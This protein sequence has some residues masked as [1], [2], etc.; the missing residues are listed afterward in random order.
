V[1]RIRLRSPLLLAAVLAVHSVAPAAEPAPEAGKYFGITVVDEETGRGV[2]LVELRTVNDIR[3]VTDSAGR[4]AFHEPALMGQAVFFHVESHGYEFP[5]DG[6]GFRGRALKVTEGGRAEL[7][8]KRLNLAERLYRV[9]GAGIY[10]DSVLLGAEP[11]LRAPVLNGRVFGSD[12]VVNAMYRGRI[13]WFWGD[14]NRPEYPLGNFHV[15]G[16]TSLLPKDGGLDPE[17]GVDLT[18]FTDETGFAKPTARLPG[19]GPTWINGL[20]VLN[21]HTDQPR[22]FAAYAKIRG[23]LEVYQRGLVEFNAE[24]NEFEKVAEFPADAAL[25]PDGHPFQHMADGAQYVY[26]AAPY[27]FVRVRAEPEALKSPA[28]YEAF[29]CL[30]EGSRLEKPELDRAADGSLRYGWKKNTPVVGWKEQERF[31]K[32]KRIEPREAWLKLRDGG[33]KTVVAHSGSVAW[34]AYRK[35]W[36]MIF[37]EAGGA[38][39]YL[40]EVWYA[41]AD[42]PEGPWLSAKKILTHNKYSFYNPKH[43]PMFDRDGGRIIYFEGTYTHTFSGNPHPTPRY[44]YNQVMYKLE[45]SRL[46]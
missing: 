16:A 23:F 18:Y 22:L 41:E 1:A 24:K 20:V 5:K 13:Y 17:A 34:N 36:V 9:T 14:T 11:P 6:F 26:F 27:P 19:D 33:G 35:R 15:P 25:Y 28:N 39:S 40:G 4:I 37:V 2:P 32:E 12:S 38:T 3:F 30:K 21:E 46:E 29:T 8:I 45:L 44:D 10:R 42:A 43:H 31:I 7:K